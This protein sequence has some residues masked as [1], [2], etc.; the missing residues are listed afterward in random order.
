MPYDVYISDS[1]HLACRAT[2]LGTF[3]EFGNAQQAAKDWLLSRGIGA[4]AYA[5]M[6]GSGLTSGVWQN[7]TERGFSTLCSSQVE[8]ECW[9][10]ERG[11]V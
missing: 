8:A 6:P 2:K 7:R 9:A 3:A 10:M 11:I 4:A 5:T 1:G